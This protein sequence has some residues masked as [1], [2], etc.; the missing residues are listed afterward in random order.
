MTRMPDTQM[1]KVNIY[2]TVD[3][4]DIADVFP[5]VVFSYV[6]QNKKD[7]Y[8]KAIDLSEK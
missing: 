8:S 7:T 5:W 1:I 3:W 2:W 4:N 6:Y